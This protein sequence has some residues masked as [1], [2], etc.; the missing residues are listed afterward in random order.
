MR[1]LV[2]IVLALVGAATGSAAAV[3]EPSIVAPGGLTPEET[4]QFVLLT[5]DDGI[6]AESRGAML[7]LLKGKTAAQGCP[8]TATMFALMDP[9]GWTSCAEVMKVYKA[10]LELADHTISHEKLPGMERSKLVN[11]IV[12]ARDKLVDCGVPKEDVV[13]LR[14]PYLDTDT[15]VREVLHQNGFLYE[16]AL[17]EDW[18]WSVSKGFGNRIWP[19][20]LKY[21]IPINCSL[22]DLVQET[23]Q[24]CGKNESW[25]G[26]WEVPT[27][28]LTNETAGER[29]YAMDPGF[30]YECGT[31]GCMNDTSSV[32]DILKDNFDRSYAGN[33]APMPVFIHIYWLQAEDNTQ[34][35]KDFIDYTLA[36]P[37][38][39]YVTMCQLLA[40]VQNPV[41]AS[42]L[43]PEMLGCGQ[44]GGRPGTLAEGGGNKQRRRALR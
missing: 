41:P 42:Q 37:N 16:A 20:D 39:Y 9:D 7:K 27:W 1:L 31:D 26:L 43:T 40:W 29:P 3:G 17:I 24:V 44:K 22:A 21:G 6:D 12:G 18:K 14:T 10:G 28:R 35:L 11:E 23:V 34:Q 19:W 30:V 32:F 36:K 5:H 4:P 33:R 15:A 38:V 13:G 2:Y 25:P 8:L